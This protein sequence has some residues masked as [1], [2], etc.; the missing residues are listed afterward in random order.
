[1]PTLPLLITALWLFKRRLRALLLSF[2]GLQSALFIALLLHPIRDPANYQSQTGKPFA[3][4]LA[5]MPAYARLNLLLHETR[6]Q[7]IDARQQPFAPAYALRAEQKWH[8][9]KMRQAAGVD[10]PWEAL[11]NE[12]QRV[13]TALPTLYHRH[14]QREAQEVE[15]YRK[16]LQKEVGSVERLKAQHR[17]EYALAKREWLNSQSAKLQL[18]VMPLWRWH[19]WEEDAGGGQDCNQIL[20]WWEL[21]RINHRDLA[22]SLLFGVRV[23]LMVGVLVVALALTL[24]LPI[25]A[26]CG[27]VGGRFDLTACRLMEIWESLPLFFMLLFIVAITECK[28]VFFVMSL[29]ALF[30]WTGLA[31]LLRGEVLKQKSWP[32]VEAARAL[33]LSHRKILGSEILPNALPPLLTLIPF[34]MLAAISA[35]AG[36]SFLGLGEEGTCSLGVLMDEG[37]S[38]FPGESYLLWPPAL[39]LTL[40]LVCIAI[41]GDAVRDAVDP[42][43]KAS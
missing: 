40:L 31:R 42:R 37:R 9:R 7:G 26:L 19:H 27:Y 21:T 13:V 25:G 41:I 36:L 2:C 20:P 22:A 24:A 39:L 14:M 30:S 18:V 33:G 3:E 8:Q 28:S 35:E 1:M 15:R 43:L 38:A 5:Q 10:R 34:A 11:S 12:E 32:Y 4:H 29:L 17:L 16:L 6:L 23:S